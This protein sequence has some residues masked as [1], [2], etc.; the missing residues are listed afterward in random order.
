MAAHNDLGIL[1]EQMARDF[2]LNKGFVIRELNWRY[3]K[4]EIDIIAQKE[5]ILAIIE[6]KT[7]STRFFG[8]PEDFIKGQ[9]INLLVRA[10]NQYVSEKNLDVEV[11]FDVI[12]IVINED[13]TTLKH[14][15]DAFFHF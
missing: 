14:L 5:K 9:K 11:R 6:V 1:G 2:L 13:E 8:D 3:K 4:A 10:A 7:R 15:E 12:G